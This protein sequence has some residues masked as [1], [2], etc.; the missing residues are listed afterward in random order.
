MDRL[1]AMRNFVR[2]VEAG[3][4]STA[5]RQLGLGQPAVSKS[6]AQLEAALGARLLSRT[7]RGLAATDTGER[8][9]D[10]ARRALDAADEADAAAREAATALTGRLRISTAVSFGRLH[11]VPRLGRF[12]A[13]HPALEIDV[14]MEDRPTDLIE[15]AV[16]VALR[17]GA[18]PDFGL[19][20]RIIATRQRC[21]VATPDYFARHG[22]PATPHD[23]ETHD[24]ITL[25][26]AAI[27]DRWTFTR[28]TETVTVQPRGRLRV[29][30]NEGVREAVLAGI[31]LTVSTHWGF[32]A[33]LADGTVTT[34]LA[35]WTLPSAPLWAI[36][37]AGRQAS[38]RARAFI[39]F[40]EREL[41]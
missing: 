6:I 28:G 2:V 34:A 7:T 32:A 30:A 39:D 38:A 9:Y 25:V 29:T 35:D 17:I 13:T 4:F 18:Q 40:L 33:E 24:A 11:V 31:G 20:G 37:P 26:Q 5:A 3:S 21:V 10:L 23:L 14:V 19:T 8:Y 36:V 12:M 1:A 22:I 41:A 16:D 15:E 27:P